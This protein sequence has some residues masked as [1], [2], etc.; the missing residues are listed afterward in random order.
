[1]LSAPD[2]GFQTGHYGR[3]CGFAGRY[4]VIFATFANLKIEVRKAQ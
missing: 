2:N 3:Y 4:S 1:M